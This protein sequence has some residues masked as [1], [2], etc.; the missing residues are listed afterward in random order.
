MPT[1]SA[2]M[3]ISGDLRITDAFMLDGYSFEPTASGFTLIFEVS[4][5]SL[6]EAQRLAA[7]NAGLIIDALSF[8]KGPALS[9]SLKRLN[10]K[11]D[12]KKAAS[13]AITLTGIVTISASAY[14]VLKTGKD[15][16]KPGI[17]LAKRVKNLRKAQALIRSLRWYARG[18]GDSDPVDKFVDFWLGFESLS[19][20]FNG[21]DV[22]AHTCGK[23]GAV[24]NPRPFG[25]VMRA[26]L[27]SV[28][29]HA[30]AESI[31]H[32]TSVRSDL[33]HRATPPTETDVKEVQEL[34]K[35]CIHEETK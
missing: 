4:A 12:E 19:L 31:S 14:V 9:F 2:E 29:L 16:V 15:G 25:G 24:I 11:P 5:S 7:E 35:K 33:M 32:L 6:D 30:D 13:G 20:T 10:E 28:G 17:E 26:Y 21:S 8:T 34:L 3:A 27:K 1:F 22:Q 18:V 23:C